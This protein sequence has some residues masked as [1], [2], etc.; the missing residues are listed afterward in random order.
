MHIPTDKTTAQ[1]TL[2]YLEK[3]NYVE[4]PTTYWRI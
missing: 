4:L 2:V 1:L 3:E